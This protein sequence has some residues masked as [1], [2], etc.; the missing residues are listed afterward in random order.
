MFEENKQKAKLLIKELAINMFAQHNQFD[1]D[2]WFIKWC[3]TTLLGLGNKKPN[4]FFDTVENTEIVCNLIL[5]M[6]YGVYL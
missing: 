5:A 2:I 4:E 6:I 3:D 1:F